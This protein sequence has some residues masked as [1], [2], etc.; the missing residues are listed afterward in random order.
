MSTGPQKYPGANI[1]HWYQDQ[2]PGDPMEV[3]RVV[4]HS[5]ET[6]DLPGYEQGRHAPN[7]TAVPDFASRKLEW[8]QHFD[9][10]VS[11]R[12]LKNL[13]G[14]VETNTLDAVQVE[15]VGTCDP[16]THVKWAAAQHLYMPE[17]P[18]WAVRDL[19]AFARWVHDNHGVGLVSGLTFKP[20]DA[21]FGAANG[22]RLSGAAWQSFKGHCG[23][24]HVPENVHGDPGAFPMTAILT[25]AGHG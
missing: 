7:L 15:I 24:Q 4:W 3:D 12:A 20:F 2:F 25:A 5:T 9:I 18:E 11:S 22:V 6:T 13:P 21:S 10:D 1:T 17:L 16:R 14:G 19:A 8:Y 23:H